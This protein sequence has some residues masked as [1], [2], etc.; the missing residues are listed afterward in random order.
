MHLFTLDEEVHINYTEQDIIALVERPFWTRGPA[1]SLEQWVLKGS[2]KKHTQ[3]TLVALWHCG[4]SWW[5]SKAEQQPKCKCIPCSLLTDTQLSAHP[6]PNTCKSP[7]GLWS[8]S[9][10]C[11]LV[12]NCSC[13][14]SRRKL[15]HGGP[16][17][18]ESPSANGG[19]GRSVFSTIGCE[20]FLGTSACLCW[21]LLSCWCGRVV[22]TCK[23]SLCP[24]SS[25][26][27]AV[28]LFYTYKTLE[29]ILNKCW[30]E[31]CVW[32]ALQDKHSFPQRKALNLMDQKRC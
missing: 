26:L 3:E 28:L 25:N 17:W 10:S 16:A 4:S 5:W 30:T 11:M 13:V 2:P 9:L 19:K 18:S 24:S 8:V 31:R 21:L 32:V 15:F 14:T 12:V 1:D 7:L 23:N 6:P 29:S 20:L 22:N 27:R